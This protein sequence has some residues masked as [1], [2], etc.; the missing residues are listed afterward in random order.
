MNFMET[1]ITQS[2]P[3]KAKEESDVF[4]YLRSLSPVGGDEMDLPHMYKHRMVLRRCS[5]GL[6]GYCMEITIVITW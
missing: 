1:G 3:P 4:V 6:R 5:S 2:I